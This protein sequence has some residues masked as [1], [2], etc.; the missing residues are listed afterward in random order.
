MKKILIIKLG[1]LGDVILSQGALKDLRAH[2][3]KDH[4]TILTTKPYEALFQKCPY[5]DEVLI[6]PRAPRWRL[7]QM[8]SLRNLLKRE[9]FSYVYDLQNQN[10]TAFY[11][12]W[13][14]KRVPWCGKAPTASCPHPF[15]LS[16]LPLWKGLRFSL[17]LRESKHSPL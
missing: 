8:W 5:V 7:D 4:I 11:H 3:A 1:A 12:K 16:P 6:D 15:D 17:R 10:R 9:D 14:L 2:H 13:F